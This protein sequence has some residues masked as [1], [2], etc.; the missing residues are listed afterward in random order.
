MMR[1]RL[2]KVTDYHITRDAYLY[3]RQAAIGPAY[4]NSEDVELQYALRQRAIALGW[5]NDRILIIDCDCGVSA[6]THAGREGF[7]SLVAAVD[8]GRAGI[9]MALDVPRFARRY[10]DWWRLV[11]VCTLTDTLILEEVAV[12]DPRDPADRLLL[13]LKATMPQL[14]ASGVRSGRGRGLVRFIES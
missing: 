6:A 12:Y 5:P 14:E 13:G 4:K 7:E 8:E 10:C 1:E 3:V 2:Q 9:V 11:E